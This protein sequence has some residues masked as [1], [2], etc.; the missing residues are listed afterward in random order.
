MSFLN[1]FFSKKKK[2]E[3]LEDAFNDL[4]PNINNN[5]ACKTFSKFLVKNLL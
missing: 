1:L 3:N 2:N 4:P 5:K